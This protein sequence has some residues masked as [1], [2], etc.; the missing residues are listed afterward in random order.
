MGWMIK[1]V[2]LVLPYIGGQPPG[3]AWLQRPY[4]RDEIQPGA[5]PAT[6]LGQGRICA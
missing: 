3:Q 5:H 1:S 6:G 2:Y 4:I